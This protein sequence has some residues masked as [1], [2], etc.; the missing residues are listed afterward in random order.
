MRRGLPPGSYAED[1]NISHGIAAN[2]ITAMHTAR[3][4]LALPRAQNIWQNFFAIYLHLSYKSRLCPAGRLSC[5]CF[6][7][8]W[9]VVNR[10]RKRYFYACS[11][12]A[13]TK[14]AQ[15]AAAPAQHTATPCQ[16][17]SAPS[18]QDQRSPRPAGR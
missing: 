16:T 3:H 15:T 5:Q 18:L 11:T 1:N 13:A 2:T 4:S 8:S 6:I 17:S 12:G 14:Q 7:P 10:S 9:R